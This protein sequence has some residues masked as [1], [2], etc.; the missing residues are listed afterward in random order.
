[1]DQL[2]SSLET[3]I[4]DGVHRVRSLWEEVWGN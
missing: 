3:G 1:M 4:E 2:C